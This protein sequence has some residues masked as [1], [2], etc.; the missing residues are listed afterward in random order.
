M[1][2]GKL[3]PAEPC[4]LE[5]TTQ[6]APSGCSASR[7][8]RGPGLPAAVGWPLAR[9][10]PPLGAGVW[11]PASQ[12]TPSQAARGCPGRHKAA[13]AGA[14]RPQDLP[15]PAAAG[16]LRRAIAWSL[17]PRAER[18]IAPRLL[19]SLLPLLCSLLSQANSP[20]GWVGRRARGASGTAAEAVQRRSPADQ[21]IQRPRPDC[22][23][24]AAPQAG[25]HAPC[26]RPSGRAGQ[27]GVEDRSPTGRAAAARARPTNPAGVPR[28]R[29]ARFA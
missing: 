4:S 14:P 5:P 16:P 20:H 29:H 28:G 24:W 22:A 11:S 25:V 17:Q 21:R 8:G 19:E 27:G 6:G 13:Q 2:V 18:L 9:R 23:A 15:G 3:A 26:S 7:T 1:L 12:R 10:P